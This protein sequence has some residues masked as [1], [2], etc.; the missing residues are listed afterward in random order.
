M[1]CVSDRPPTVTVIIPAKDS[2]A[3]LEEALD[4]V[5]AQTYTGIAEIVVAAADPESAAVARGFG[6][7]V[8]E[9]PSGRT[10]TALNLAIAASTGEV[11]VRCD[12]QSKLDPRYVEKA[13]ATLTRTGADNVGGMQIPIGNTFWERAIAAAMASLLGSGDARYRLG[14]EEGPVETVYLG[15]F[16][17]STLERVGGFDETFTRTQDYELNHRIIGAGG[18]VWFDPGLRAEYRPRGSLRAL[19][20]QYFDY[21]RSKRRFD[22]KH[23][24]SLRWRQLAAPGLVLAMAGS[25]LVAPLWPVTL[26]MPAAYVGAAVAT[27]AIAARRVGMAALGTPPALITMHVMWGLGF[28]RG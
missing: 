1:T 4:S 13:V 6:A 28:F 8:V 25:I 27:G 15:V 5:A 23:P 14:G 12:A 19:A 17:R 16:R 21:G 3:S 7:T 26:I 24:G 20:R 11:V 18:T 2:A 10:P 9:N 22:R